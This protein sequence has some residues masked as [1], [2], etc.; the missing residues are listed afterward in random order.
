[1][2]RCVSFLATRYC[3]ID[4][5]SEHPE[6]NASIAAKQVTNEKQRTSG[7]RRA[8]TGNLRMVEFISVESISKELASNERDDVEIGDRRRT[9][10]STST[11]RVWVTIKVGEAVTS[12]VAFCPASK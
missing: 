8:T 5:S 12:G 3:R 1:M 11:A 9:N 6:R 7:L 2:V 10:H 4:V